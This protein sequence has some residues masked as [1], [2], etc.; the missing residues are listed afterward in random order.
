MVGNDLIKYFQI[1]GFDLDQAEDLKSATFLKLFGGGLQTYTPDKGPLSS[2]IFILSRNEALQQKRRDRYKKE[3][4]LEIVLRT[5]T[6]DRDWELVEAAPHE[7]SEVCEIAMR[8]LNED[9]RC[10]IGWRF[11][12][13]ETCAMIAKRL[14]VSGNTVRKRQSRIFDKLRKELERIGF[15]ELQGQTK[16]T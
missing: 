7:M 4:Q 5:S 2:W 14:G 1:L 11:L 16:G 3:I 13:D 12:E 6:R 10:M 8:S 15:R 9:E